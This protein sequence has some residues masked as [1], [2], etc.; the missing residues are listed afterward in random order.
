MDAPH[1]TLEALTEEVTTLRRQDQRLRLILDGVRDHA[2]SMLDPEGCVETFNAP[3]A[4]IKGYALEEVR[5]RYYGMFFTPDDRASGLPEEELAVARSAGRYEGEGWR[6]RKDGSHFY[7]RVSLSALRGDAGELLGF[8]KVTQDITVQRALTEEARRAEEWLRFLSEASATLVASLD[9]RRTLATLARLCVPLLADWAAIDMLGPNRTIERLAVVHTDPARVDL[10]HE[11]FRRWPPTMDDP[12]GVAH[13]LRTGQPEVYHEIDDA[14]LEA[15]LPDP[16]LLGIARSIGLSSSMCVPLMVR[17]R[18]VGAISLAA[19]ESGRRFGADS[20]RLAEDLARRAS[21][22]VENA[23]LYRE[24]TE[25]SQLKDEFL[26]TLS[27]EL[28]TP[29]TAVLG[30]ATLLRTRQDDPAQVSKGLATIERNARVQAQLIDDLLDLSRIVTGVLRLEVQPVEVGALVETAIDTVRPAANAKGLAL[31]SV[32]DP[33]AGAVMG[34]PGRLGQVF[35]NLLTNAT[36]FTPKGGAVRVVVRRV[37]SSVEIL[38][39]DNGLGIEPA[40][41]PHVFERF[42]QA[43]G[44]S[45]RAQGGLGLGLA[46]CRSLV[47]LHGGTIGA[48]SEGPGKGA[49]FTVRL[50]VTPLRTSLAPAASDAATGAAAGETSS[51][52]PRSLEGVR[53]LIVDDE[54]DTRELLL[55]LLQQCKATAR[56]AGSAAEAM[57]MLRHEVPDVL[58]SDVGMPGEDGLTFIRRVRALPPAQ[59]GRVPAIALT[60]YAAP[61]DRTRAFVA[62]FD[63]FV[64]KP[65]DSHELIV[66][67]ANLVGRYSR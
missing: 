50:P 33:R 11:L 61:G 46:I 43:D 26:A 5:G 65:I 7:A 54:P 17:G 66:V 41:L 14:L 29:L 4:R 59:G 22:A 42:R 64:S 2:I 52:L 19:A 6:Q 3:A 55:V 9:Y 20:L 25:A 34:D 24:V 27:H 67:I 32:I 23:S 10:A 31:Q 8:V 39:R 35:N 47:E 48:D 16:E 49:T 1:A 21:V 56:A 51:A 18:V 28:R 30:W 62:G 15:A 36:K 45:T 38:V 44:S 37:D 12:H 53:V 58:V 40:F 13:V 57:A 60:A 63:Q